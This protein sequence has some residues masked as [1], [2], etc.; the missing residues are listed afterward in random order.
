MNETFED[1][2]FG[3]LIV[4]RQ[5]LLRKILE[6]TNPNKQ[7]LHINRCKGTGKMNLL[8]LLGQELA[9][10][11]KTSPEVLKNN[12]YHHITTIGLGVP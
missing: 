12:T 6:L 8:H 1:I 7:S 10:Q 5:Q 2:G 9:F 11:G 4:W 3:P